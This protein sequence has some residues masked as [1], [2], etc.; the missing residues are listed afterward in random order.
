MMARPLL[1]GLA[2]RHVQV[3]H[4]MSR[5]SEDLRLERRTG[6]PHSHER[7][8]GMRDRAEPQRVQAKRQGESNQDT[9]LTQ[10]VRAYCR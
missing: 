7:L 4:G 2:R 6:Q 5:Q 1:T 8:R 3:V 10:G 9:T